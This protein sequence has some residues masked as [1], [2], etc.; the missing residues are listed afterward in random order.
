MQAGPKPMLTLTPSRVVGR[1]PPTIALFQVSV[2]ADKFVPVI[3]AHAFEV[4]P[5]AK[6]APF[7]MPLI[8]GQ[9]PV[10]PLP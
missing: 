3:V 4:T 2:T 5:L 9:P 7:E 1:F 10:A 6:L 8:V